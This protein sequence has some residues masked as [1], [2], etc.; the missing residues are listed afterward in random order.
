MSD[1]I[2]H[3]KLDQDC[4][5]IGNLPLCRVLMMN[6]RQYPWFILVPRR[7]GVREIYELSSE[8][9]RIFWHESAWFSEQIMEIFNGEKL[10]VAALGN[11]VPQLHVHHIVRNQY[12]ACWPSPVW[13][14]VPPRPF[15]VE[16][17]AARI[18][19]METLLSNYS[20]PE[21]VFTEA[22]AEERWG[23]KRT[24]KK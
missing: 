16:D 8:D 1:F 15:S 19:N 11:V 12:D 17:A 7:A 4:F 22:E 21:P 2:L 5:K 14:A 23:G 20:A 3:S 13:G 6:D 9:Q 10:N 24:K 18:E